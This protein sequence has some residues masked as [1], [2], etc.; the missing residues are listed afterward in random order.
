MV[1]DGVGGAEAGELAS[2]AAA[3]ELR[4]QF[5]FEPNAFDLTQAISAANAQVLALQDQTHKQMKTTAA[6]VLVSQDEIRCAHVGD[7]RIYLFSE[8]GICYQSVDHSVSQVA[9]MTGEIRPDEIRQHR[10]RNKLLRALGAEDEMPVDEK[11][12]ARAGM[13]ALLICSDG[14]WEY[15]LEDEMVRLLQEA[16][17]AEQW[18]GEM[19]ALLQERI[20]QRNDNNTAIAAIF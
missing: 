14:F 15:V 2:K 17:T 9:V 4:G 13:K 3:D 18:L 8:S 7:T 10:D 11:A 12:F 20:P 19:R 5:L 16:A 1:A 6:A